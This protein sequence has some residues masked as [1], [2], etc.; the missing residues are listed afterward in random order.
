[1]ART[2]DLVFAGTV[3]STWTAAAP[4]TIITRVTFRDLA[5]GKGHAPGDSLILNVNGGTLL[6]RTVDD[7]EEPEFHAGDRC[8]VFARG[9]LGSFANHYRAVVGGWQGVFNVAYDSTSGMTGVR[10]RYELPLAAINGEGVVVADGK[11]AFTRLSEK[12]FL[13]A[14][15]RIAEHPKPTA[16]DSL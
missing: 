6:G 8:I 3:A 10:Q 14:V 15:G 13:A 5:F 11:L 16:T 9:D 2:A 1:M 12:D 4:G 7:G